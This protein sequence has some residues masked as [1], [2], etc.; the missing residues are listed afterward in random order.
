MVEIR[1]L[2]EMLK[3]TGF[4]IEKTDTVDGFITTYIAKKKA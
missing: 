2:E 1:I 4:L 3:K